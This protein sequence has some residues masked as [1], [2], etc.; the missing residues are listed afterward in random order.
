MVQHRVRR[1]P[2][3]DGARARR[4]RHPR[5]HRGPHRQPRGRPADDRRGD[6]G[7]PAPVLLPRERLRMTGEVV[8]PCSFERERRWALPVALLTL[9]S[10]ALLI[11]LGR[12]DR[13][14]VSGDGEARGA[15]APP[16]ST[17]PT[18]PYSSILQAIA[19][20]LLAAPLTYLF[21]ATSARAPKVPHPADRPGDARRRSSSPERLD[22]QCGRDPRRRLG[23]VRLR[24][25][26]DQLHREGRGRGLPRMNG[27]D[28]RRTPTARTSAAG[29]SA[30]AQKCADTRVEDETASDAIADAPTQRAGDRGLGLGGRF[31]LGLI[32]NSS[33][34]ACG[35]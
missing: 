3:V 9:A 1:L 16:T 8:R 28:G 31:G 13:S 27:R 21:L 29:G 7:R 25:G 2:V 23:G 6:R 5:R 30:A 34:P 4:H 11:G 12:G 24:Q 14:S 15:S 19:F 10:I 18:S 26:D 22:P 35:R 33:T 17:A 20:A 32:I